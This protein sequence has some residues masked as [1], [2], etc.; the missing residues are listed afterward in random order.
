[1]LKIA[2]TFALVGF[3]PGLLIYS[4]SYQFVSRSIESWFDVKVEGALEA[5]LNLGRVTLD[6]LSNDLANK[7]RIAATQ[8]ADSS[9]NGTDVMLARVMEQLGATEAT[10][11][12]SGGK[13]LASVGPIGFQLSP[14]KPSGSQ[15][16]TARAE[17]SLAWVDGLEEGGPGKRGTPSIKALVP[18]ASA[19]VGLATE[20]CTC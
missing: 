4:V 11:W 19:S 14:D 1:L 20:Q 17:R 6:T 13:L 16:R 8:L 12:S 7:A 3:L 2:A 9:D 10:V 5:G 18:I 15:F